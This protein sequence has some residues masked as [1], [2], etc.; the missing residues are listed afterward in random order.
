MPAVWDRNWT[1]HCQGAKEFVREWKNELS[2]VLS[3]V[4]DGCDNYF[5]KVTRQVTD[6]PINGLTFFTV[7]KHNGNRLFR[8]GIWWGDDRQRTDSD[9]F[10][11]TLYLECSS[12]DIGS[13]QHVSPNHINSIELYL[14]PFDRSFFHQHH[15]DRP[16]RT[17]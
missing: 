1:D 15:I 14:S 6:Q 4:Y 12:H 5:P 10:P 3:E 7:K 11:P 8:A 16:L 17:T 13:I 9:Y 2:T